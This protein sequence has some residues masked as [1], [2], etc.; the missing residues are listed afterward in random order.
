V[1]A[2]TLR[3]SRRSFWLLHS[4]MLELGNA[5]GDQ[6]GERRTDELG[7]RRVTGLA[8]IRAR[9]RVMRPMRIEILA[10]SRRPISASARTQKRP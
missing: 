4:S 5:I 2:K 7:A 1:N 8:T 10:A 6:R 9:A 3:L